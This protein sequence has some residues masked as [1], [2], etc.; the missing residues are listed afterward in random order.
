MV[1]RVSV[2]PAKVGVKIVLTT[3]M[4]STESAH[5]GRAEH[6]VQSCAVSYYPP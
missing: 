2:T 1:L 3:T 4:R 5:M 6:L